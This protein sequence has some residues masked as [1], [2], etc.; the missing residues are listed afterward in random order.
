MPSAA[1]A[2]SRRL[3]HG[4]E[5]GD[6]RALAVGAGNVDRRRNPILRIAE[7]REERPH[8]VERELAGVGTLRL[9]RI[10]DPMDALVGGGQGPLLGP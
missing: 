9:E 10:E 5:E 3:A 2:T 7:T 6:E 8:L 4:A 1:F